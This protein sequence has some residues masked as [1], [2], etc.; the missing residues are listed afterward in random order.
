MDTAVNITKPNW[1]KIFVKEIRWENY[2]ASSS[3]VV[4]TSTGGT[5][6]NEQI[7]ATGND[8]FQVM[9]FGPFGWVNDLE[10]TTITAGS[11]ITITITKS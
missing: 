6:I 9:R 8:D 2:A 7:P 5:I 3:L 10:I 11:N 1:G 4:V